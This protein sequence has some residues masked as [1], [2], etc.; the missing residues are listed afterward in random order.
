VS[1][2]PTSKRIAAGT[3]TAS[4][5]AASAERRAAERRDVLRATQAAREQR[6]EF[7]RAL[8]RALGDHEDERDA[9]PTTGLPIPPV[10]AEASKAHP[11]GPEVSKADP[12]RPEA[13]KD[14]AE[15]SKPLHPAQEPFDASGRTAARADMASVHPGNPPQASSTSANPATPAPHNAP[16]L[17]DFTRL[18]DT[19]PAADASRWR[20][21][22]ADATL[23]IQRLDLQRPPGGT[24][25]L[26]LTPRDGRHAAPAESALSRLQ[27]RLSARGAA[28]AELHPTPSDD[29]LHDA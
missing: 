20:F 28:V 2:W 4:D 12:V 3:A 14:G 6:G 24:L 1:T 25:H 21:E 10:P 16:Q 13:S 5:A 19:T 22:L 7:E 18:R 11:V 29:P 17:D 27:Q 8:R 26:A 9:P 15:A 23:P